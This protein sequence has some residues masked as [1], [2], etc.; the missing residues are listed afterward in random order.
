MKLADLVEQKRNI[1][2]M[3]FDDSPHRRLKIGEPVKVAGVVCAATRFEG[4]VWGEIGKDSMDTTEVFTQMV[5]GSK[6][7]E[8]LHLILLDGITFGGSNVVDLPQLAA[9]TGLPAVTV[10]RRRPQMKKF[11]AVLD[12]LPDPGE[13]RRRMAAAGPIHEH[14]DF[15]FQV[16]GEDPD[17]VGPALS[18]LTDRGKVPE[19]LR[20]AHLIGS[21][22]VTGQSGKRA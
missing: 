20:I 15:F 16:A 9:D 3:G 4:M 5:I 21:A 22:V 17:V 12:R 18:R 10:M 11:S 7:L 13:R 1:R 6:F 2:V 19:A 14:A 8:Q